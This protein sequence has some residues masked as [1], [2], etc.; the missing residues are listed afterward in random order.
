[1]PAM[2]GRNHSLLDVLVSGFDQAL[3]T[4]AGSAAG[5]G[6]PNPAKQAAPAGEETLADA[7]RRHVA[8]LM[9][10]NHSGEVAAQALYQ[11]Q[12]LTARLENVREAMERA[13]VEE[14]DHLK[15]C[16]ERLQELGSHTSVLNPL[17]Y[18]G[19]FAI[20]ALAG[21]AG[22]RWSL[23]FVAETEKQVVDH[24]Q[25]HLERLPLEDERSRA[26][27]EQMK[28]D[29][30]HHGQAAADAGGARLPA[31]FRHLMTLTSRVMTRTAY[32]I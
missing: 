18:A 4:M 30:Q 12:A 10:V 21:I 2:T 1:M 13:A 29:E 26:I 7:Q 32:W 3:K 23:G 14:I 16:Q 17:W 15:W 6:R 31:P 8:G 5:S 22:D 19:S 20:G 27:L 9:R 24:L 11:G 28:Q 25:G